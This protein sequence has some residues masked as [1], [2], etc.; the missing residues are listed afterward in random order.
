MTKTRKKIVIQGVRGAFH[1]IAARYYHEDPIDVVPAITFNELIIES[2]KYDGGMMAIEN[3]I[4]GTLIRNFP[5]IQHSPLE[6]TGEIYLRIKHN[7]MALPGQDISDIKEV[8][9][10]PMAIEQCRE[11]FKP[12]KH[13]RLVETEDTAL[14]ARFIFER[15]TPNVA[16]IASAK[17]AELYELDI[18]AEGIETNK[19]NYTRFLSLEHRDK[20]IDDS[21]FEKVSICFAVQHEIGRL[22]EVL[23]LLAD[24]KANLTKI[25]SVP[26]IGDRW[27]YFFFVDFVLEAPQDF[28]RTIKELTKA[29]TGL[30]MLGRYKTGVHYEN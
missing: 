7:L 2:P 11:Y 14:S 6:I 26:I 10:H 1:E 30:Q 9:S 27:R 19:Q 22:H 28:D 8:H 23:K 5:L 4:A 20:Y 29:T 25:Q 24:H 21:E 13:I 3:S 16:A 12:Y 18:L 17:A 15:R